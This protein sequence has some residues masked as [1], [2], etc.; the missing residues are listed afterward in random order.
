MG[1]ILQEYLVL[2]TPFIGHI[3]TLH[4]NK[5]R[6]HTILVV[7]QYLNEVGILLLLVPAKKPNLNSI[8]YFWISCE[9]Y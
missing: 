6:P 5:A 1:N 4:H 8:E 3:F 2:Y 7:Y 9:A